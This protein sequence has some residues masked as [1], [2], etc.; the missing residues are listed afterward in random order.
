[1]CDIHT[2]VLWYLR[3]MAFS[4]CVTE[5]EF[6][7]QKKVFE[8]T[9]FDIFLTQILGRK[10]FLLSPLPF[11]F[12]LT[13]F[14]LNFFPIFECFSLTKTG[15]VIV[16][17][18]AYT[19]QNFLKVILNLLDLCVPQCFFKRDLTARSANV[20][21]GLALNFIELA[22]NVNTDSLFSGSFIVTSKNGETPRIDALQF[23][24]T[25]GELWVM[26]YKCCTI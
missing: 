7:P 12:N 8:P 16:K 2:N 14:S 25:V 22:V 1:M 20:I 21:I 26:V 4:A 15:A 9:C 6:Y 11:C 19:F 17:Q 5:K 18:T 3:Y 13:T 24:C 23:R 10:D